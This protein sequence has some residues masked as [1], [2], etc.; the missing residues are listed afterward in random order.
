MVNT[1]KKKRCY[2]VPG[3]IHGKLGGGLMGET[4][5]HN[6]GHPFN[7]LMKRSVEDRVVITMND[8][9]PGRHTVYKLSSIRQ[10]NVNAVSRSDI[11]GWYW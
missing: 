5:K 11:I 7:L 4:A 8:T 9:P 10:F 2:L 3:H 6:M 1:N